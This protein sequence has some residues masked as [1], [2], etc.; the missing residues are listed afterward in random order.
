MLLISI[1]LAALNL[2]SLR[3]FIKEKEPARV[4]AVYTFIATLGLV[5]GILISIDKTPT[6]PAEWIQKI[7]EH[8]G[9]IK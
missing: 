6:S 8:M 2:Y 1:I 5:I 7:L 4:I 3:R 9:V